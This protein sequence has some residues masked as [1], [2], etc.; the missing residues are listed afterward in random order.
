MADNFNEIVG[1]VRRSKWPRWDWYLYL[2]YLVAMAIAYGLTAF[3]FLP[4]AWGATI[5][6][7]IIMSRPLLIFMLPDVFLDDEVRNERERKELK[8]VFLAAIV[9]LIVA[10]WR[11]FSADLGDGVK[12]SLLVPMFI[13]A[14]TS[15]PKTPS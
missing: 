10:T 8:V 3:D 2:V 9:C 7:W 6:L 5:C 1:Q 13:A 12:G 4:L 11:Y 14:H 15:K